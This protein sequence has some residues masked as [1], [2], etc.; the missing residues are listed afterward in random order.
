MHNTLGYT[1]ELN[2]YNLKLD[3]IKERIHF[4]IIKIL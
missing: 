4:A 1:V 3:F 2:P